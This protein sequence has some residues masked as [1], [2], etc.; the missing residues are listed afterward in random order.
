MREVIVGVAGVQR[1]DE[2]RKRAPTRDLAQRTEGA[3][4]GEVQRRRRGGVLARRRDGSGETQE[5]LILRL[6]RILD[7]AVELLI[8]AGSLRGVQIAAT[9]DLTV[10][11]VKVQRAG[12]VVEIPEGEELHLLW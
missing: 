9:D 6:E 4:P 1:R 10:G 8:R 5:G 11:R 7:V 3:R 2:V 12:D